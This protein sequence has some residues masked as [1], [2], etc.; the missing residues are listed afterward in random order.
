MHFGVSWCSN[1]EKIIMK[2]GT[3]I[4]QTINEDK[5]QVLY[6]YIHDIVYMHDL[7]SVP[8]DSV[9]IIMKSG[10]A[11]DKYENQVHYMTLHN[12]CTGWH[13]YKVFDQ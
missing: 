7:F 11:N 3:C 9:K 10:N 1:S 6:I 2:S 5:N 12:T 8:T 4:R 13:N